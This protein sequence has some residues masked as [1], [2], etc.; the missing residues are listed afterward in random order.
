MRNLEPRGV[1]RLANIMVEEGLEPK[2]VLPQNP[3]VV[4][5]SFLAFKLSLIGFAYFGVSL[6]L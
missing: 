2:S 3:P 1:K 5:T 4:F 6:K